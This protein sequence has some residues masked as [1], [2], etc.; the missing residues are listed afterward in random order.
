MGKLGVPPPS[1]AWV[2]ALSA[3]PLVLL[4]AGAFELAGRSLGPN[5]I[6]EL[7]HVTGKTA[8]NMVLITLMVSPARALTGDPRWLR[9]RRMLGLWAFAY[10]ALHLLIYIV[11]ELDL[12]LRDLG[13]ELAKRPFIWV[14]AAALVGLLPLAV[15]STDRWMRRLGRRWQTLHWLVYPVA[16]LSVWHFWWQVKADIREPLLYA[17]VLAALLA[18][19]VWRRRRTHLARRTTIN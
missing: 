3:V 8:L 10:A 18:W 2:F 15:T 7:T 6:R 5:P 17:S 13:R 16:V 11:L 19:R 14:G 1:K 12:D 4:I 9:I